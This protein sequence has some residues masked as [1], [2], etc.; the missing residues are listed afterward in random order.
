MLHGLASSQWSCVPYDSSRVLG[1]CIFEDDGRPFDEQDV[2]VITIHREGS[3]R[4]QEDKIGRFGV[5]F[6][7]VLRIFR[8]TALWSPTSLL[9]DHRLVL[10]TALPPRNDLG[11]KTRFEFPFKYSRKALR[12]P[13]KKWMQVSAAWPRRRS[14]LPPSHLTTIHW[15]VCED[16]S[17]GL[18]LN[19]GLRRRIMSRRWS[20]KTM[21]GQLATRT[22]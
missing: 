7:A 1:R 18:F 3:R 9:Q 15:R 16:V 4:D 19:G 6:K 5:G 20:D 17:G 11:S 13:S 8:D 10:P 14:F 2:W 22:F 12:M 21:E